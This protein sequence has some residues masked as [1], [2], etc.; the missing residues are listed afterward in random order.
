MSEAP[1]TL[2]GR[3]F[4]P[5]VQG[6]IANDCWTMGR[7]QRAG[8]TSVPRAENQSAESWA[9]DVLAAVM[10]SGRLLE[11]LGGLLVPVE[12]EDS[13]WSEDLAR[14]T[15]A[16]IGGLT[17][18]DDKA[19]VQALTL[20][21]LLPFFESE[22]ASSRSSAASLTPGPGAGSSA[23]TSEPATISGSGGR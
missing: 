16:F 7:I 20:S 21:V 3:K 18:P 23:T 1:I 6:S 8:L 5:V 14:Q 17:A 13:A 11:L 10:E 12:I 4:R 2:G 9:R 15:A 19:T 22:L